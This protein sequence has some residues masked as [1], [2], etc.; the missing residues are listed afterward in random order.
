M[1]RQN[2]NELV[3]RNRIMIICK[4]NVRMCKVNVPKGTTTGTIN[5]S[6]SC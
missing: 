3:K 2:N 6:E 4:V 1:M 5:E